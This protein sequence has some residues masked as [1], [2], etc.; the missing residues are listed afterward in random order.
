MDGRGRVKVWTQC[1]NI[2][3]PHEAGAEEYFD[4][5]GW[6]HGISGVAGGEL[7]QGG[8]RLRG[9]SHR[10]HFSLS[11]R[12]DLRQREEFVVWS[13]QIWC[14]EASSELRVQ[15]LARASSATKSP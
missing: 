8:R 1:M 2:F 10:R 14:W 15:L 13:T 4:D 7:R 11:S 5:S 6:G 12:A 3:T 9:R